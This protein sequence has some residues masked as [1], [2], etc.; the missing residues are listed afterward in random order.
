MQK[1]DDHAAT[2]LEYQSPGLRR[3]P[4]DPVAIAAGVAGAA[5][6]AGL[7][8][9]C[10]GAQGPGVILTLVGGLASLVLGIAG[11]VRTRRIERIEVV[12]F[13]KPRGGGGVFARAALV[14]GMLFVLVLFMLPS[15]GR[16]RESANRVKCASNLR[17]IGQ[18][19]RQYAVDFGGP[20]PSVE[21]LLDESDLVPE[22]FLCPSANET[23]TGRPLVFGENLSYHLFSLD[24]T[25]PTINVLVTCDPLNH[26]PT[27]GSTRTHGGNALF[28]DG[29]VTFLEDGDFLD[30]LRMTFGT[31]FEALPTTRP[32]KAR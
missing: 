30:A 18:S 5:T 19:L 24:A 27:D 26:L 4:P 16:A 8:F 21:V 23:E 9:F 2:P 32:G 7:A 10:G 17:Q 25:R 13:A 15:L 28:A 1:E 31:I 14:V 20:P 6:L 12:R 11:V 29:S 3:D 22:V